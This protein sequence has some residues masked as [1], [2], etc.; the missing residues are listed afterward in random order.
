MNYLSLKLCVR[1]EVLKSKLLAPKCERHVESV[2]CIYDC[3]L[4][5]GHNDHVS[6]LKLKFDICL[7]T[8]SKS[9]VSEPHTISAVIW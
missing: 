4:G 6:K 5:T 3:A 1:S 9:N 7:S 8:N 2:H